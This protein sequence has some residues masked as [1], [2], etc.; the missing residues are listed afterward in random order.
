M[1]AG[2]KKTLNILFWVFVAALYLNIGYWF[3][4]A[5]DNVCVKGVAD[6]DGWE[7]FL[8]FKGYLPSIFY[9]VK[10]SCDV[11]P[12]HISYLAFYM[13]ELFWPIQFLGAL[14]CWSWWFLFDGGMFKTAAK[15]AGMISAIWSQ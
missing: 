1:K 3:A 2:V 12:G 7:K 10:S 13:I 5:L 11:T 8:T 15:L 4:S 9:V 6:L 14:V